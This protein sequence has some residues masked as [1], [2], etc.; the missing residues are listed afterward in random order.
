MKI[1]KRGCNTVMVDFDEKKIFHKLVNMNRTTLASV[2]SSL[3]YII[4][5]SD[6]RCLN[7]KEAMILVLR[8]NDMWEDKE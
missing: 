2:L 4:K 5:E 8:L 1:H 3:I 7:M 6:D